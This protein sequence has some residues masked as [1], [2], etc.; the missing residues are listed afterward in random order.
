MATIYNMA[1]TTSKTFTI[2]DGGITIFSGIGTPIDEMGNIGD[3]YVQKEIDN[4][5]FGR[6][7]H[8]EVFDGVAKWNFIKTYTFDDDI[9]HAIETSTNSNN[10]KITLESA[11]NSSIV[12]STKQNDYTNNHSAYG[13]TRFATTNE[14]YA[15]N[16]GVDKFIVETPA[17]I[18][19]DINVEKTRAEG[20]EQNLQNQIGDLSQLTTPDTANLVA[21]NNSLQSQ[22][23][24]IV[25]KSDV[26]DLVGT[27]AELMVY[28]THELGDDDVI[29]VLQ[30]ETNSQATTYYRFTPVPT[31]PAVSVATKTALDAYPTTSLSIGDVAKVDADETHSGEEAYYVWRKLNGTPSWIYAGPC[32]TS[33]PH[34]SGKYYWDRIGEEGPFYTKS[35]A[36]GR[37]VHLTGDETISGVKTFTNNIRLNTSANE[38]DYLVKN[39]N[40]DTTDASRPNSIYSWFRM[41]DKNDN[42]VND[43]GF[44]QEDDGDSITLMQARKI[45]NNESI[46]SRMGVQVDNNGNTST[47]VTTPSASNSKSLADI[48]NV[49]WVNDPNKSLNV[50]HRDGDE[51][52]TGT[53]TMTGATVL[54]A[55]QNTNDNSTKAASTAF[56]HNLVDTSLLPVHDSSTAGKYL[57]VDNNGDTVWASINNV[58]LSDL[59]DVYIT[60]P[61]SGQ[62]II[63]D[64]T[65]NSNAGGWKNGSQVTATIKYW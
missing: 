58:P 63:Y 45:V 20:A 46:V 61:T 65:L 44:A 4:S 5:D 6:I 33:V 18:K 12:S 39:E 40:L 56:V 55:T 62:T 52:I 57:S 30:D 17:Q 43:L 24:T 36:D 47:F 34:T 64:Q 37:F 15:G 31:T 3:I 11:D 28:D 60:N 21:S 26:V 7:Y 23:D 42:I 14:T 35:E 10:F 8:K 22:I 32:D 9:I 41:V 29:K 59:S 48:A 1:G 54:V 13:V 2:G 38:I 49:G 25:S 53:K 19:A 27:Y 51:T 50:V 16:S